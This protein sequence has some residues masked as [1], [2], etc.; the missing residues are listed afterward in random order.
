MPD[1]ALD[2]V[3]VN[4]RRCVAISEHKSHL[5]F[6]ISGDDDNKVVNRVARDVS[7]MIGG[8]PIR[9]IIEDSFTLILYSSEYYTNLIKPYYQ[10]VEDYIYNYLLSKGSCTYSFF[11]YHGSQI[12]FKP[13]MRL[14]T[15][16][17]SMRNYSCVER[18]II[19]KT[20]AKKTVIY[21]GLRPCYYCLPAIRDV[22]YRD[23]CSI[24]ELKSSLYSRN[25][26]KFSLIKK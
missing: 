23:G 10:S 2:I 15:S 17:H 5:Y 14:Y 12:R 22:I 20:K 21:V 24:Y 25:T 1:N 26:F 18:K 16:I 4:R 9:C 13:F 7:N 19:G 11:D 8:S 3:R 6:A